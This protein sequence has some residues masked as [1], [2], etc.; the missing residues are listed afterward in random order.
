MINAL[1]LRDNAKQQLAE[2]KTIE[3]GVEYL[4]KVKA[5]ETWAKAEKKDAELQNII[6]EQKLRTQRILGN[7]LKESNV[8]KN[9]GNRFIDGKTLAPS[10]TLSSIGINKQQSSAFQKIASLPQEIFEEEIALAKEETNKRI[11]LTTSRMITAAKNYQKEDKKKEWQEKVNKEPQTNSFIDIFNTNK[12]F[13]VIYADPPWSY[14]DKKK[15]H[16]TGGATDHY[17]TMDLNEICDLPIKNLLEKDAVLFLWVTSPLLEDSFE[18]I[19]KWGFKYKTSFIWDK[20]KHNM[21]H[22]NSVRHEFLLV[23]TKGSCIP[24]NKKLYNSVQSIERNNN[25]SEKPIEFINIIDDLYNYGDKIELFAR[26][27]KKDNWF[28]WG[29]EL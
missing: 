6:A 23:A 16:L 26:E 15:A 9:V 4:N 5:I 12:K 27:L 19:N 7:L 17:Q 21:G 2:I 10:K 20:V 28:G 3:T 25:H 14:N 8:T 22:Y 18:V 24:D 1:Q 29:N 13:R 11:E